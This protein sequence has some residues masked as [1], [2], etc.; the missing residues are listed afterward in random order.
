MSKKIMLLALA[1]VSA[2]LFAL[3]T[4]ASAQTWHL[5]ATTSFSV[6]GSVGNFTSTDGTKI[7]CTSETGSGTFSTTTSGSL[8][9]I[10]HGCTGPF[11]FACTTPGQSSGT[12]TVSY[13]FNGI[14]V[15]S[16]AS[17]KDPGILMT[18]SGPAGPTGGKQ[19]TEMSCLGISIKIYGNGVIGT[20]HNP[21]SPCG[22][23]GTTWG[24]NFES[25]IEGHQKDMTWT[26]VT[27]DKYSNA[28]ASH[29]TNSTDSTTTLTFPA[30]RTLTCT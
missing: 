22:A 16:T 8:S 1:A 18:P 29:P 25:S 17:T 28:S 2:A 21:A 26:G 12:V 11:G 20:I 27:Y 6:T 23:T 19:F 5:S 15:T 24:L 30:S 13:S 4:V 10:T 3:P 7:T 14:M 9:L